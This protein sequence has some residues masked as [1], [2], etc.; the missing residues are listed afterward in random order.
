MDNT[1]GD[2]LEAIDGLV[3]EAQD[4]RDALMQARGL[5]AGN[6]QTGPALL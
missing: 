3:S 5:I 1:H 6:L 4:C 2:A